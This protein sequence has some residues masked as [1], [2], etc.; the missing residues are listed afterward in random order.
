MATEIQNDKEVA[1][2]LMK[3]LKEDT[4]RVSILTDD[5]LYSL[6]MQSGQ[7]IIA[8]TTFEAM[9]LKKELLEG[10]FALNLEKP[11]LIQNIAIPCILAKKS[12]AFQSN[13]G[14]GK[15][16]AFVISA[17]QLA[18]PG[19]AQQILILSP[20]RELSA[21]VGKVAEKISGFVGMKVCF[22]LGDFSGDSIKEEF[23]VGCPGKVMSLINSK[24]I[25]PESIKLVIF[26]EADELITNQAFSTLTL[27]LLRMLE[28]AQKIFFSATYSELSKKALTKLAPKAEHFLQDKNEK[29][30]KIKLYY[31]EVE[32]NQKNQLLK[33]LFEFL[34][35]AQTVVFVS[36]KASVDYLSEFLI[37]DGFSVS[38]IHGAMDPEQRD[39]AFQEFMKANT[40]ILVTTNVFSRGMDIPQVN[41]IINYDIPN[42]SSAEDQQTYIHRI[43]RSGRFNRAG[44][45]IDFVTG[46]EELTVLAGIQSSMGAISKKFTLPALQEAFYESDN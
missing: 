9:K 31:V 33:S 20:T 7:E 37:K 46:V 14:T 11:S 8:A 45:V 19:V 38:K 3:S 17:A 6:Q 39:L 36:T 22:A 23:I 5:K 13:S 40:K 2:E 28:K 35:I 25:T 15:T 32:K 1:A 18:E 21:Q 10:M 27:K 41:L 34:T 12:A 24:V 44:F 4:S 30:E 43:G 42:F 26:D 16:M 29:A